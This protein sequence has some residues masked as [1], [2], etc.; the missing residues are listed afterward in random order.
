MRS[1]AAL[2]LCDSVEMSDEN[3]GRGATANCL[4]VISDSLFIDHVPMTQQGVANLPPS[5]SE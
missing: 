4:G 1:I 5:L 3:F 2:R